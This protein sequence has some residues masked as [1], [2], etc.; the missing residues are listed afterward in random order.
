MLRAL[1]YSLILSLG[2]GAS[3][4]VRADAP[5][6]SAT[7][8]ASPR[9]A[10]ATD[11]RSVAAAVQAFYDQTDTLEASFVQTHH[12]RVY[13][14]TQRSTGRLVLDKP[15]RLRFDYDD[16]KVFVSDGRHFLAYDP[17]DDG[18]PGQ[19]VKTAVGSSDLPSAFAFLTGQRRVEEYRTRLLDGRRYGWSGP[20]LEMVP[21]SRDPQMRR[22]VLF[23]DARL[24][25]VV[26][27]L[28]VEDHEGN[29]NQFELR[30]VRYDREVGAARFQFTPPAGSRRVS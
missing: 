20:V 11:A 7:A 30:Q 4:A 24:P 22:L 12:H 1:T 19:Y 14:R 26:H 5:T 15:G 10:V 29:S 13:Q 16:G 28:R 8:L 23:V 9:A 2:L 3:F 25:G 18:A 21:R 17:G 6:E 27:R